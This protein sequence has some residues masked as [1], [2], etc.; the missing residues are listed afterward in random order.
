MLKVWWSGRH[1]YG[2]ILTPLILQR[3][4]IKFQYVGRQHADTMCIGSIAKYSR[5]GVKMMG[6]G[7]MRVSDPVSPDAQWLWARGPRTR[8][9]VLEYGGQCPETY[10]DM[11]MLLPELVDEAPKMH[12][13]GIIPHKVDYH[14]CRAVY[15]KYPIVRL[16]TN[17]CVA[18]T[19][20]ITRCRSVISSSL[21]GIIVAHAYGIPAAWV[22]FSDKLNGDGS[23]FHDHHESLGLKA[24]LS[25]LENP[26]FQVGSLSTAHMKDALRCY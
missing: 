22:K 8:A 14:Y 16:H 11:A 12:D 19:A 17:D 1:N 10:G 4:G 2:D 21:H 24:V 13:V 26:V 3:M 25:T 9:K 7:I 18:T 5:P 15:R 23:K 6:T 20:H